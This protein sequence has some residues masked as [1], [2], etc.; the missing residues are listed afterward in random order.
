MKMTR[1]QAILMLLGSIAGKA[2]IDAPSLTVKDDGHEQGWTTY[3]IGAWRDTQTLSLDLADRSPTLS[4]A[5]PVFRGID[6][7]EIRYNGET[8]TIT[9]KEI[10][11][12][13]A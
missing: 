6:S 10:W 9:A 7:I 5:F 3:V 1:K 12:A 13:L 4:P 8:R 2:Q 11:K